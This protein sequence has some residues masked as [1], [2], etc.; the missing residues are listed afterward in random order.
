MQCCTP[1]CE[2]D[3]EEETA[4]EIEEMVEEVVE[5][6]IEEEDPEVIEEEEP[7]VEEEDDIIEEEEPVDDI[8]VGNTPEVDGADELEC[9]EK[10]EI[11]DKLCVLPWDLPDVTV[12]GIVED[13]L[14]SGDCPE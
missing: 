1:D 13:A 3:D 10:A 7:V 11:E 2:C 6:V 9:Q 14:G 12:E 5:E 8:V 4:V